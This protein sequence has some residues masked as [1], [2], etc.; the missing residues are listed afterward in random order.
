MADTTAVNGNTNPNVQALK[1][2]EV[3]GYLSLG[4][5]FFFL[6]VSLPSTSG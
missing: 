2:S 5:F 4:V 3:C 6:A 1:D